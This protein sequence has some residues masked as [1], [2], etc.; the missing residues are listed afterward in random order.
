MDLLPDEITREA[1]TQL[2]AEFG[3]GLV[4]RTEQA[5]KGQLHSSAGNSTTSV[6]SVDLVIELAKLLAVLAPLAVEIWQSTGKSSDR[7]ALT[8]KLKEET[9]KKQKEGASNWPLG[10]PGATV[11]RAVNIMLDIIE[12]KW[13]KAA[14]KAI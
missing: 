14:P 6:G 4:K 1:A 8:K 12:R 11:D 13:G 7:N 3:S 2:S 10:L 5:L 9:K